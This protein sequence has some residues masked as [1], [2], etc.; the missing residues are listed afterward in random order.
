LSPIPASRK[1]Q[2]AAFAVHL[3]TAAG[4]AIAFGALIAAISGEFTVM[5]GLLAIALLIDGVDGT[6]ARRLRVAEVL[7]RWSG[8][9]LDLV[10][11]YLNYVFVPAVAL[12]SGAILPQRLAIPA[13]IAILISSAIY[14]AD[15]HM[16]T[17]D[18]YFRGFP[19]LWNLVAFYLFLLHPEPIISLAVVA[20]FV[21][22]TF[23]PI[24][25][26]HPLRAKRWPGLNL[27]TMAAGVVFGMAALFYHLNPPQPVIV[28]LLVVAVYFLVAG[29]ARPS[30]RST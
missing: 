5:F 4:A 15:T 19:A 26:A 28:G 21:V 9:A 13:A 2:A 14:F 11:D 23:I 25:F 29:F 7:P 17:R 12:A 16:K 20:I 3:F 10:V 24:Y 8:D 6:F 22:M 27:A 30:K 1:Q 18:G